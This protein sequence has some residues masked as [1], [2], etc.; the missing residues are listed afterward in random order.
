MELRYIFLSQSIATFLKFLMKEKRRAVK[1]K[2]NLS[3]SIIRGTLCVL[4]MKLYPSVIY[5]VPHERGIHEITLNDK[6]NFYSHCLY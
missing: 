2:K 4:L 1:N 6:V 5:S 3:G